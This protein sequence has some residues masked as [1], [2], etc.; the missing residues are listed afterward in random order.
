MTNNISMRLLAVLGVLA[1]GASAGAQ[2]VR[3]DT[4]RADSVRATSPRGGRK[5]DGTKNPT[6]QGGKPGGVVAN[7]VVKQGKAAGARR[8]S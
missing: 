2:Q 3:T 4:H 6:T 1:I 8:R 7:S 5:Q